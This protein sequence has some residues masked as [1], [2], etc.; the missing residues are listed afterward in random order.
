[1]SELFR[2]P[3]SISAAGPREQLTPVSWR[4]RQIGRPDQSRPRSCRLRFN[5]REHCRTVMVEDP[6]PQARSISKGAETFQGF[7]ANCL[8]DVV[9]VFDIKAEAYGN[10]VDLPFVA[11]QQLNPGLLVAVDTSGDEGMIAAP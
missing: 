5:N 8:K 11:I 9:P 2:I 6:V 4:G 7:E 10:T 3:C 1:M